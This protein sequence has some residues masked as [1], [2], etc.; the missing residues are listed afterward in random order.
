VRVHSSL[1]TAAVFMAGCVPPSYGIF[2]S[3]RLEAP[4]DLACV[5]GVLERTGAASIRFYDAEA[6]RTLPFQNRGPGFIYEAPGGTYL[7][8]FFIDPEGPVDLLHYAP[9][10][11]ETPISTL[12]GLRAHLEA[13][14]LLLQQECGVD[15]LM[16]A[17]EEE[18]RGVNCSEL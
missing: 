11:R 14:D 8:Q 3:A 18:C 4:P 13:L 16:D 6:G 17:I 12:R 9:A 10:E 2:R 7:V 5:R 15:G 1:V